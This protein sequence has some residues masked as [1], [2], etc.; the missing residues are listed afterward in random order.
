MEPDE[1]KEFLLDY[2]NF[3]F[4]NE[5]DGEY[6]E[7]NLQDIFNLRQYK[8]IAEDFTL[9]IEEYLK[10]ENKK[11]DLNDPEDRKKFKQIIFHES[12]K[13]LNEEKA[14][15]Y[16]KSKRDNEIEG[17]NFSNSGRSKNSLPK[18]D[19]QN[20]EMHNFNNNNI[21]HYDD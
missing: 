13:F 14:R 3:R 12:I 21:G 2:L 1:K 20:E 6:F 5:I 17:D 16:L 10:N 8:L 4:G 11:F 19:S 15:N 7:K 9:M 18:I